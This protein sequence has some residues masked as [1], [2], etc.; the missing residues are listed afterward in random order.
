MV[1]S[2]KGRPIGLQE[3]CNQ[4]HQYIMEHKLPPTTVGYNVTQKTAMLN[5]ENTET[6]S[7]THLDVYK[8]QGV[9]RR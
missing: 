5:P 9:Y 7:Y 3:A 8:R 4:L 2:Y 6:V 1:A